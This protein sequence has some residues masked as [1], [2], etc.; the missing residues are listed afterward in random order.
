MLSSNE[1]NM[2]A[3]V[4][5]DRAIDCALDWESWLNSPRVR[6]GG[7][8]MPSVP[9]MLQFQLCQG[10]VTVLDVPDSVDYF[11]MTSMMHN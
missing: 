11:W 8:K 7:L 9:G 5:L 4:F 2:N 6:G 10:L 1:L 3:Q